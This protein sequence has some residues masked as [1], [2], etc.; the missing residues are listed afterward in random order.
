V[1]PIG[2]LENASQ[3]VPVTKHY[4]DCQI[5]KERG[6]TFRNAVGKLEKW[7]RLP[8]RPRR[9]WVDRT[10]LAAKETGCEKGLIS[11]VWLMPLNH[12]DK[13]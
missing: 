7:K 3:F 4:H 12:L 5:K 11:A 2:A 1:F 13:R 6:C 9:K 8:G 10:D